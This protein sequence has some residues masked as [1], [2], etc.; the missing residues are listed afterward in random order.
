MHVAVVVVTLLDE[1]TVVHA[2]NFIV[3]PRIISFST[4][5]QY[6]WKRGKGLSNEP[7]LF[8]NTNLNLKTGRKLELT[9]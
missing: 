9:L 3:A 4:F 1:K 8:A 6:K 2:F 5:C 7:L